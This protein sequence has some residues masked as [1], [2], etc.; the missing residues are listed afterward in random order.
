MGGR[1]RGN[2]TRNC[3][4]VEPLTTDFNK[5]NC[6][7]TNGLTSTK[8]FFDNGSKIKV[9]EH[10]TEKHVTYAFNDSCYHG[11]VVCFTRNPVKQHGAN[12]PLDDLHILQT[13]H[14]SDLVGCVVCN[15]RLAVWVGNISTYRGGGRRSVQNKLLRHHEGHNGRYTWK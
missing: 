4:K 9:F 13:D 12:G 11:I 5:G 15:P 7:V 3:T 8:T 6:I 14:C 10:N 2:Q 1:E